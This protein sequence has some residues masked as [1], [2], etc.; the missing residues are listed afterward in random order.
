VKYEKKYFSGSV[1]VRNLMMSC[2]RNNEGVAWWEEEV[3]VVVV[4]VVGG[5]GVQTSG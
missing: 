3:V 4:V 5:G 2:S 1:C